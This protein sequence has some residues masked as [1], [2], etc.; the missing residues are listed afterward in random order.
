[1]KNLSRLYLTLSLALLTSG[2]MLLPDTV[3]SLLYFDREAITAGQLWSLVSGH[4]M[5]ADSEHWLWN[6]LALLALG[7]FIEYYS[8]RLLLFSLI[9]GILMVDALLLSPLCELRFYCGLSGILN[10]LLIMALWLAWK[11]SHSGWVLFSALLGMGKLGLEMTLNQSVLT[12]ISWPPYPASHLAGAIAGIATVS[13]AMTI[14]IS[15]R[16]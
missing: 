12:Q 7:G 8:R 3:K 11:A 6:N 9:A 2:L 15:D 16:P 5:H 4:F 13:L 10:S 14:F 1:M